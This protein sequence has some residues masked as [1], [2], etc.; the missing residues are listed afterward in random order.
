MKKTAYISGVILLAG[1]VYLLQSCTTVP[2]TNYIHA[3]QSAE[4][5]S[6]TEASLDQTD[7][8]LFISLYQNLDAPDVGERVKQAYADTL[9]FN[10]TLNTHTNLDT[11]TPYLVKTGEH[12]M[13]YDFDITQSFK[14][15]QDVY[16]KWVM[17]MTFDVMGKRIHSESIGISQLRFNSDGKIIFHQDFWDS[18]EGIHK[19]M[20]YVGHWVKKVRDK[21]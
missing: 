4:K 10:D 20:P 16:V 6:A 9:Y 5:A 21:L 18:A 17:D 12:L 1:S 11:L 7:I 19:H 2:D 8:S 13:G 3:Y 15:D 14:S